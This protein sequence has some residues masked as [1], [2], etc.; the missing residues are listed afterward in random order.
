M[1]ISDEDK[2]VRCLFEYACK[3]KLY[4]VIHELLE[5]FPTSTQI[6]HIRLA[7]AAISK[8][9]TDEDVENYD[10]ALTI[11]EEIHIYSKTKVYEQLKESFQ[12]KT[13]ENADT[14]KRVLGNCVNVLEAKLPLRNVQQ[15]HQS[16]SMRILSDGLLNHLQTGSHDDLLGLAKLLGSHTQSHEELMDNAQSRLSCSF[17]MLTGRSIVPDN[18]SPVEGD[19]IYTVSSSSDSGPLTQSGV[20]DKE[21]ETCSQDHVS[22][23]D[24]HEDILCQQD[25]SPTFSSHEKRVGR[26]NDPSTEDII[27]ASSDDETSSI[28]SFPQIKVSKRFGG[29]CVIKLHKDASLSESISDPKTNQP[30]DIFR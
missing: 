11:I 28:E 10:L 26:R 1:S 4:D 29:L 20:T 5:K 7:L 16:S 17:S 3:Y 6:S 22:E 19:Q 25:V 30:V 18:T 21:H 24:E 2:I 13:N 15:T 8:I 27:L 14:L 9:V 12:K 23:T